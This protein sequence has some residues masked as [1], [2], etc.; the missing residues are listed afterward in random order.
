MSTPLDGF[1]I[2]SFWFRSDTHTSFKNLGIGG[3]PLEDPKL[4]F[5]VLDRGVLEVEFSE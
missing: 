5:T 1:L 2:T 3:R 4:P